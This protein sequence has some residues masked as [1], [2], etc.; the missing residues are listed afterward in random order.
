MSKQ[1]ELNTASEQELER[2]QGIGKDHARK[3]VEFRNQNGPFKGWE[4]VKKISGVPGNMMEMLKR[5]GF[6]VGGKAA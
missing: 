1:M 5:Q 4:D 6:T 3:I 2:I